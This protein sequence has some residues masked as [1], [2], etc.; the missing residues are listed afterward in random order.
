MGIQVVVM[1]DFRTGRK[2]KCTCSARRCRRFDAWAWKC[3]LL[4]ALLLCRWETPAAAQG[5]SNFITL[6][7][8][9][10]LI[11]VTNSF[12]DSYYFLLNSTSL[13]T[14][15]TPASA[16]LGSEGSTLFQTNL[17]PFGSMF[18]QVEQFPLNGTNS[19]LHDGIADG[20]KL[21]H[22]LPVFGPSEATIVP[23]FYK[24][25]WRAIYQTQTNL[26]ALPLAFFPTNSITVVVGL[27]NVSIPVSFSKLFEG[28]LTYQLS[29]TAIPRSTGVTGNYVQPVGSVFVNNAMTA[30][31][32]IPLVQEQDI[33]INRS[34]VIALS[35]PPLGSQTYTITTNSC[36]ATVQI[37]QSSFSSNGL[38]VGSLTFTNGLFAGGQS[39][40]MAM[41]PG[42]GNSTVALLD[43]TGNPL[44][45]NTF[46]VAVNAST[47]GFQLNG[48]Q[49]TNIVTNTPWGRSLNVA[50]SFGSTQTN[51]NGM[52]Y[53]TPVTMSL[54][55]LTASGITYS[56]S[57]TLNLAPS[58]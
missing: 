39:V 55:G 4:I 2:T 34:I 13:S 35:A 3:C 36:V 21:Q 9:S 20:W 50:L 18:F 52:T 16:L 40:K 14:N 17:Y 48:G 42:S 49:L 58:Q 29:G 51:T 19:Y 57:G 26:A 43:V 25:N 7:N 11:D 33:E 8:G 37:V 41:R 46:S 53:T 44:L 38:F 1:N 27:S 10:V 47:N 24:T 28:T 31:I 5:L 6:S 54:G 30:N 32:V 45:G 15:F 56:G 22:G 12:S 23:T